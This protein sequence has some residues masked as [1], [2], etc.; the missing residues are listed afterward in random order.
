MSGAIARNLGGIAFDF[1]VGW[2]YELLSSWLSIYV[3]LCCFV[4]EHVLRSVQAHA[5]KQR[6]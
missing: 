6:P 2:R 5:T 1:G 3:E 4:G